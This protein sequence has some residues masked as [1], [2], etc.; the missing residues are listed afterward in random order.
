MYVY[1]V[2]RMPSPMRLT[3]LTGAACVP[4]MLKRC[5]NSGVTRVMEPSDGG[6]VPALAF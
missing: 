1:A 4:V 6:G 3:P 2:S 5:L